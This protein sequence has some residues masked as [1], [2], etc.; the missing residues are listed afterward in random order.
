MD[1]TLAALLFRASE[2]PERALS[3]G[4]AVA[5]AG[6]DVPAPRLGIAALPGAPGWSAAFYTSGTGKGEDE[7]EHVVELFEDELSPAVAVLDAA[8]E[9]GAPAQDA[10]VLTLV[11]SEDVLHDEAWRFT[12]QGFERRFVREGDTGIEAGVETPSGC[13]VTEVAIALPEGAGEVE[14]RAAVERATRP[15]RGSTFLSAALGIPLLPALMGALFALERTLDV[16]LVEPDP[17]SIVAEVG[18]LCRVLARVEGRGAVP[19]PPSISG[20]TQPAQHAAFVGAYD[21]A[22]P[23][24]P[25]DVFRELSIGAI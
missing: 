13:E 20:V 6:W 4:F 17:A 5:L 24:D 11:R 22:D 23:A 3:R 7:L 8:V 25:R 12:A 9:M 18:R 14:E 21:W 19:A 16:R 1:T 15:H 2:V 10:T